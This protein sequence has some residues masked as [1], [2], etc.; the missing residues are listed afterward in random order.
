MKGLLLTVSLALG[1]LAPAAYAGDIGSVRSRLTLSPLAEIHMPAAWQGIWDQHDV[2][3]DCATLVQIAET[4]VRDT[5]CAND[6]YN[7]GF[8][9]TG[10]I[11][12]TS[13]DITCTSTFTVFEGC[14]ATITVHSTGTRNS[15]SYTAVSTVNTT[16][17]GSNCGGIPN[18][19]TRSEVTATRIG[20]ATSACTTPL[21]PTSWSR[22]KAR[23]TG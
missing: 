21:E 2:V 18:S 12:D 9:C 4:T 1:L 14:S 10:S 20:N 23:Y 6:S 16:Y 8:D 19:C 22:L 11:T 17:N 5:L 3:K 13:F 7:Q 15:D